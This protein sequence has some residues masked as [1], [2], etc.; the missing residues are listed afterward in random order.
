MC[1]SLGDKSQGK[2][3]IKIC[4]TKKV[5]K[6]KTAVKKKIAKKTTKKISKKTTVKTETEE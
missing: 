6:K 1:R 5:A 3:L 4:S 2:L